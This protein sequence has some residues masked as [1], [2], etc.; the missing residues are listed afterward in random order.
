MNVLLHCSSSSRLAMLGKLWRG[1][2][3]HA[4]RST[5]PRDPSPCSTEPTWREAP[6]RSSLLLGTATPLPL[7]GSSCSLLFHLVLS[8][9]SLCSTIGTRRLGV[10]RGFHMSYRTATDYR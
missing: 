1:G 4:E 6:T 3:Q 7:H 2:R 8:R 5:W 9:L 10:F